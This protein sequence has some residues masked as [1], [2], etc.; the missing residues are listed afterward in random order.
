V[1]C[2][3]GP[4]PSYTPPDPRVIEAQQ[5]AEQASQLNALGIKAYNDSQWQTAADYFQQALDLEPNSDTFKKNLALANEMLARKRAADQRAKEQ[6]EKD[7]EFERQND[8]LVDQ[9]KDLIPKASTGGPKKDA[10]RSDA[11][12]VI[13]ESDYFFS[14]QTGKLEPLNDGGHPIESSEQTSTINHGLVGG[15]SWTYGF[16]W[17]K[18]P[19]SGECQS[20]I[21]S[22]LDKQLSLYCSSQDD[23]A[24]CVREGLPFTPADYDLV[25]SMGTYHS[26]IQDL[27]TRVVFD[28]VTFGKF[29]A[30]HKEIFAGLLDRQFN[31]LD[32]HSNGAM[33]CLAALESGRTKAAEVRLFGPQIDPAAAEK[34]KAL[35]SKGVKVEIYID[36]G[37]P[38]PALAWQQPRMSVGQAVT[39]LWSASATTLTTFVAKTAIAAYEDARTHWVDTDLN[40]YGF[41]VTRLT[42]SSTMNADCHAMKAYES[43]LKNTPGKP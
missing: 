22:A 13:R 9:L 36:N 38:V 27:A 11:T 29:T 39:T 3:N 18:A 7:E 21:K 32:C 15:T 31:T 17:P 33:L 20:A 42:C 1:P 26:F 19:C 14:L 10:K 8:A 40:K 6:R 34:W 24:Q 2:V 25:I 16:K 4:P 35:A 41:T 30:E 43:G 37:D 28:G 5:K 12:N 23:P